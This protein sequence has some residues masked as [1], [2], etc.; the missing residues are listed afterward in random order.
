[1]R[2]LGRHHTQPHIDRWPSSD[3]DSARSPK[4]PAAAV[5]RGAGAGG[6]PDPQ[7][8]CSIFDVT[9]THVN[10]T[11]TAAVASSCLSPHRSISHK[12]VVFVVVSS[13]SLPYVLACRSRTVS[14]CRTVISLVED[15]KNGAVKVL[16]RRETASHSVAKIC[17][18]LWSVVRVQRAAPTRRATLAPTPS[19]HQWRA[20]RP[21]Q[22]ITVVLPCFSTPNAV[23]CAITHQMSHAVHW[24]LHKLSVSWQSLFTSSAAVLKKS[25]RKYRTWWFWVI[26]QYWAR[27]WRFYLDDH[28]SVRFCTPFL[29]F[30]RIQKRNR[31][32]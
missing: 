15:G 31:Q 3:D 6:P 16:W 1:M 4:Q 8:L 28:V 10:L 11:A 17:D 26:K 13:P 18:G 7:P 12:T 21:P 20:P 24:T 32:C 25:D 27:T 22:V 2:S 30:S 14:S 19:C 9:T 29:R 23:Q 5:G